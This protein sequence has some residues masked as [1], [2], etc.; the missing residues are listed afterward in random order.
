MNSINHISDRLGEK[1]LNQELSYKLIIT[2]NVSTVIV[3]QLK[4][5]NWYDKQDHSLDPHTDQLPTKKKSP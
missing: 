1:I 2:Y 3:Q 4:I 5:C